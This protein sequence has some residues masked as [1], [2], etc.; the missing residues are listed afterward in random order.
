LEVP[1]LTPV[2]IAV[3]GAGYWGRKVMREVQAIAR[4]DSSVALRYVVDDSPTAL[5]QCR[6]EFGP[7]DYRLDYHTLL[8]D[9]ELQ[10]VH[11]CT[12]NDSHFEV[13]S[14][15]I[16][17]GKNVLV[18][19][20]LTL[21]SSEAYQLVQL[22]QDNKVV[23]CVGH[24][25]RFNN[26]VRELKRALATGVLGNPYYL[27]LEWT[28][29]LP[30]QVRR[31]VITDLAPHPF[32]ICNYLTGRWP[33]N[34]SCRAKGYRT[35]NNEEIAFIS[36]E[37]EDGLYAHIEVSWLDWTKR[38]NL[39]LVAGGGIAS[40]DCL[41]QKALLQQKDKTEQVPIVPSNTLREEIKHFTN[42]V[43]HHIMSKPYSNNSDGMLGA[44]VVTCLEAAR[45]SLA[46]ER[47]VNIQLP[48]SREV[49]LPQ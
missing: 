2:G 16:K 47:T 49:P 24:I 28:G 22:A 14:A 43:S 26:G 20:P 46:K 44:H 31:D 27:R 10:A 35:L 48:L 4:E 15:F 17:A 36:C 40:L 9:P 39:T 19:K 12:P 11:I 37:Y 33:V 8:S 18:E 7:S 1:A 13:A 5:D 21:K 23:L 6:R 38:R 3:I 45:E 29:F 30:P 42:C 32:D 41:D 34:I 25:H